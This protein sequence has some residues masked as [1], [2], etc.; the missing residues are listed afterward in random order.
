MEQE[1]K[2]EAIVNKVA[3][4]LFIY[5]SNNLQ[6]SFKSDK[7]YLCAVSKNFVL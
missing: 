6:I 5:Y 2:V 3:Q 4:Y 1:T 7:D